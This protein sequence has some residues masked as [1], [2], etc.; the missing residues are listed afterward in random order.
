MG[1]VSQHS[2]SFDTGLRVI[3][4]WARTTNLKHSRWTLPR[5]LRRLL[6]LRAVITWGGFGQL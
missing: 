4:M 1:T 2:F 5:L 6:R 3:N